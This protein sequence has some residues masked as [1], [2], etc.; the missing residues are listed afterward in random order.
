MFL[1]KCLNKDPLKRATVDELLRDPFVNGMPIEHYELHTD[2]LY[3]FPAFYNTNPCL[4]KITMCQISLGHAVD[5]A[6]V[7]IQDASIKFET[8][9]TKTKDGYQFVTYQQIVSMLKQLGY[10][11]EI[12]HTIAANSFALFG[13]RYNVNISELETL[14]YNENE[15]II[16]NNSNNNHSNSVWV[17]GID[18]SSWKKIL[19][20]AMLS[21]DREY[22]AGFANTFDRND[23][24]LI[25]AQDVVYV[26]KDSF[27][28]YGEYIEMDMDQIKFWK[29][30][31]NETG[32]HMY[33]WDE[34]AHCLFAEISGQYGVDKPY[35]TVS[36][37]E[38]TNA[39]MC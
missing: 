39:L 31:E 36:V 8:M 17:E 14:N 33:K 11:I 1:V 3:S 6:D 5:S 22:C 25:T 35:E 30:R 19:H 16:N 29:A 18:F 9:C 10:H 26:I 20:F 27:R 24:G 21:N 34:M 13:K 4:I 23:D 7:T 2:I 37:Q 28:Q 12:A 15:T 38:F 32:R